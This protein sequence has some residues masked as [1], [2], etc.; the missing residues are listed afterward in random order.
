MFLGDKS[1]RHHLPGYILAHAVLS[2][3][4]EEEGQI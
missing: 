3:F 2:I 4:K 1:T